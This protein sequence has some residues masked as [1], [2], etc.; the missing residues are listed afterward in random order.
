[1]AAIFDTGS[2]AALLSVTELVRSAAC[3]KLLLDIAASSAAADSLSHVYLWLS[4]HMSSL[5]F[6]SEQIFIS[7]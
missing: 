4:G 2:P 7:L 1:M 3:V 6:V 5:C